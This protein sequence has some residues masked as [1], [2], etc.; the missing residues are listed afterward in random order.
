LLLLAYARLDLS[1]SELPAPGVVRVDEVRVGVEPARLDP[2]RRV[3]DCRVGLL[4]VTKPFGRGLSTTTLSRRL[5]WTASDSPDRDCV[6]ATCSGELHARADSEGDLRSATVQVCQRHAR[7]RSSSGT[8]RDDQRASPTYPET[9]RRTRR[10]GCRGSSQ[11]SWTS[12]HPS[13]SARDSRGTERGLRRGSGAP[14]T[15]SSTSARPR[16]RPVRPA[17]D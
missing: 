10:L 1:G 5:I 8:A 11:S 3:S 7:V 6:P 13:A 4:G 15:R 12:R 16:R 17:D 9:C 2:R 14:R